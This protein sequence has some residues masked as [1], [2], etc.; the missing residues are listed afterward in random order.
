MMIVMT[1]TRSRETIPN[2]ETESAAPVSGIPYI[3]YI[4]IPKDGDVCYHIANDIE[5]SS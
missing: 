3:L 2:N 1:M 4:I 5:N